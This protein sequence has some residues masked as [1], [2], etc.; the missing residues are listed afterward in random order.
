MKVTVAVPAYNEEG[1]LEDT[2]KGIRGELQ[3][4]DRVDSFEIIVSE[5]GSEDDTGEI[6]ESLEKSFEQVEHL[7]LGDLKGKGKA[8]EEA[9]NRSELDYFIFMDADGATAVEELEEMVE[10][11]ESG[12]VVI[13]SRRSDDADRDLLRDVASNLFNYSVRILFFSGISDHQCGFKGFRREAVES[14][15]EDVESDHWFWDTEFLVKAQ[16]NNL[17]VDVLPVDWEEKGDSEIDLFS[18]GLYF[19]RRLAEL[20]IKQWLD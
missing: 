4:L 15:V 7:D 2:V 8:V 17:D 12:D 6:A 9:F 5:G 13:G 16:Q 11:L 3:S 18:D 19:S 14:V 10:R 1:Y 20:R